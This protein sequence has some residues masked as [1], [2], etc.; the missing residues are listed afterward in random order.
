MSRFPAENT[1]MANRGA[2]AI[3]VIFGVGLAMAAGSVWYHYGQGRQCLE[4]WGQHDGE[5]IRHAP[6]VELWVLGEPEEPEQAGEA[7]DPLEI[8][9]QPRR[10]VRRLDISQAR[11]LVHARHAL[12]L[13]ANYLW[14]PTDGRE[15][16][17]VARWTHA[18]AFSRG[19]DRV[20]LMF[21]FDR[22]HVRRL[23]LPQ[24]LQLVPTIAA[25]EQAL[26]Q[27]ELGR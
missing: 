5:L 11:G 14:P 8:D 9:G 20:V 25:A 24:A 16:V 17:N 15:P 12:I 3:A 13:D 6:M 1:P 19:S 18:L 2:W 21:D 27:R 26:L 7:A 4:F 22:G 23:T 10:I